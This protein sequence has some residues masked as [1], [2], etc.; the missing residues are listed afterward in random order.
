M[1]PFFIITNSKFFYCINMIVLQE[2]ASVQTIKFIPRQFTIGNSYNITIVNESTN[3]EVY[4]QDT[5][6]ISSELYYN[7]YSD[8]FNLKEDVF[9]NIE[10]KDAK[11]IF[12]D[13]IFC[14]N[15]TNLPE[16]SINN[17]EYV[18]NQTDNEFITF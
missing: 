13:K 18:S 3:V 1:L 7:L 17:G 14:T 16:Y 4:N 8:I 5:T 9:Y 2:S 11:V 10:I 12:K 15:Q 6:G